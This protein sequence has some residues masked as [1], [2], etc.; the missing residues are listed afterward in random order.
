MSLDPP[1]TPYALDSPIAEN[2]LRSSQ[3]ESL[4][5]LQDDRFQQAATAGRGVDLSFLSAN[6]S[7]E[8]LDANGDSPVA[9]T[10]ASNSA[11]TNPLVPFHNRR[12]S[13]NGSTPTP[14]LGNSPVGQQSHSHHQRTNSNS[15]GSRPRPRSLLGSESLNYAIWEDGAPTQEKIA[16]KRH[17]AYF[18][19]KLTPLAAPIDTRKGSLRSGSPVRSTS[20]VRRGNT[21]PYRRNSSP[22]REPFNFKLQDL[23]MS[24]SNSSNLSLVVKPAH[25]KGH[26]YKHSSVSMNLFQEPVPIADANLQQNLIPDLY[27][28]PNFK[29]SLTSAG[30]SQK[31][32]LMLSLA[33]F[34]VSVLVFLVGVKFHQ[35]TFST[36]AH[37]VFYDSLGSFVVA[38]VDVVSNFEVWSKSSIAYPFGLGRLEVLTGFALSA[39]LVMVGCDLVSHFVEELVVSYV[40]ASED[41]IEHGAHH[42]HG[43]ATESV[44]WMLYETVLVAV[45]AITWFTSRYIFD[46]GNISR[47]LT[48]TD[49]V[50]LKARLSK[51]RKGGIL[52]STE[53]EER[54]FLVLIKS[55]FH[56][57][58]KNPIRM[59]TLVYS[60]FLVFLPIISSSESIGFDISE[61]STLVVA[62]TLCYAG[63]NLVRTLGG[64]LLISFPYSDYDYNVLRATITEKIF[65]LPSFKSSYLI[66][67]V[68]VTKV[69]YE[70]YIAC[71]AV[72]M[73]GGS[74]DD[75]SRLLFEINRIFERTI[76][77]FDA[78]SKVETTI[79]ITRA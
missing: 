23:S 71:M 7:S 37:L 60:V 54:N 47:M 52:S 8:S 63:W 50:L 28:I 34:A 20:P 78:D 15:G 43:S 4:Q 53:N 26:R 69:N 38:C 5:S 35:P 51:A 48:E 77:D 1:S 56:V 41:S 76:G 18:G 25:R 42:I 44:N 21:S 55:V 74:A 49:V 62:A 46:G 16:S 36:L 6:F 30:P 79:S 11:Y 73:K 31:L 29:E 72:T 64:I 10:R 9:S 27:P 2:R 45:I 70:L 75:E 65:G 58:V 22:S 13:A 24:H 39:S 14:S 12:Y 57:L 40:N 61:L 66:N 33:H 17:S 32:K 59:L 3:H 19:S 67:S 68:F